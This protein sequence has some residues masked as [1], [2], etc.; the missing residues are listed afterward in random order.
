MRTI[1]RTW[2][3]DPLYQGFV[4]SVYLGVMLRSVGGGGGYSGLF[5]STE[6]YL[7]SSLTAAKAVR[8]RSFKPLNA[9]LT[10]IQAKRE[11]VGSSEGPMSYTLLPATIH[12]SMYRRSAQHGWSLVTSEPVLVRP[13]CFRVIYT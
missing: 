13:D 4:E 3:R 2:R 9:A 6:F 11:C 5:S 1:A 10:H 7:Q 12:R 8:T